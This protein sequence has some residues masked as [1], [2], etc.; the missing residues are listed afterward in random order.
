MT[1]LWSTSETT[2]TILVTA[3]GIYSVDITN[4]ANC[5]S[6]K[7]ITVIEHHTPEIDRIDV[8]ETTVVIYLKNPKDYFEYSVDGINYQ[9][10]NVFFNVASG[11]QTAYAREINSCGIDSKTFIVLIAPKFFTPNNDSH[12]DV[13][14]I[15]ALLYYPDA[16]VSIFDR[17]GK[18]I[19]KLNTAKPS[20]DGTFNKNPL[21]ASDYWYVLKIDAN[22]PEKRG[23][24]SLKR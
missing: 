19:T 21:P 11:L 12:N 23:H 17:Y 6:I 1:Y 9:S 7:K 20:W 24:F 16:E 4:N 5:T 15:K 14:E 2:Q 8:N 18:L 3:P 10:S 13:W 22:S